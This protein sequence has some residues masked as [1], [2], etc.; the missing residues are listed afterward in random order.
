MFA[1]AFL[2]GYLPHNHSKIMACGLFYEVKI[3]K[4]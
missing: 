1:N 2:S 3:F 4:K